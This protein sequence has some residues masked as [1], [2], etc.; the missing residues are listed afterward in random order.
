MLHWFLPCNNVLLLSCAVVSDSLRSHGLQRSRLPH[1]K[2]YPGLWSHVHWISDTL[3]LSHPLLPSSPPA[4][5][6]F[7][8]LSLFRWICAT[9]KWPKFCSF[10]FNINTSN[11]YSGL[12]SLK[13]WLVLFLGVQGTLKSSLQHHRWKTSFFQHSAFFMVH[14]SHLYDYWKKISFD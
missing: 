11:E 4:F 12:I 13:D 10:S 3:Q 6:L 5:N 2:L 8:N 9:I 1:P 7:Q 14:L